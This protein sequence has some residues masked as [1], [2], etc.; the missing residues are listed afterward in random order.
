MIP[1]RD[2]NVSTNPG[3][4]FL[5]FAEDWY[6]DYIDVIMPEAGTNVTIT[7]PTGGT[8]TSTVVDEVFHFDIPEFSAAGQGVYEITAT[9]PVWVVIISRLGDQQGYFVWRGISADCPVPDLD[10]DGIVNAFDNCPTICNP[11]Q[12]DTGNPGTLNDGIGDACDGPGDRELYYGVAVSHGP[13]KVMDSVPSADDVHVPGCPVIWAGFDGVADT[14]A[15]VDDVQELPV[16][17][18]ND[19]DPLPGLQSDTILDAPDNCPGVCNVSQ[20][21]TDLDGIGDACCPGIVPGTDYC[22]SGNSTGHDY[23]WGFDDSGDGSVVLGEPRDLNAATPAAGSD[24]SA[25]AFA[26][27]DSIVDEGT[28]NLTS[29]LVNCFTILPATPSPGPL[30]VGEAG[31]APICK[32]TASGCSYNPEIF[33]LASGSPGLTVSGS[34]ADTDLDWTSLLMGSTYDVVRG[35]V[36]TLLANGGDF[37]LATAECVAD[38][39]VGNTLTFSGDPAAGEA[40]WFLVRGA[41]CGGGTY[42]TEGSA[43]AA[44]RDGGIAAS[45]SGCP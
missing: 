19:C 37:D 21:D 23:S 15:V 30:Y 41:H 13:N 43:Q 22:I 4:S 34:G 38:N 39:H 6:Q 28:Y 14:I 16:G 5:L 20:D 11:S 26:F 40:F 35:D 45:G 12:A 27:A 44:P 8:H 1:G 3:T 2:G 25:L 33:C 17:D 10:G 32:V 9:K 24:A 31:V 42:D 7:G 18:A 29:P 36:G